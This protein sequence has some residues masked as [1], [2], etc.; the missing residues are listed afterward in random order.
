MLLSGEIS[1]SVYFNAVGGD[2]YRA[3]VEGEQDG[4]EAILFLLL[5]SLFQSSLESDG[6]VFQYYSETEFRHLQS[7]GSLDWPDF[8]KAFPVLAVLVQMSGNLFKV[9]SD[10]GRPIEKSDTWKDLIR[11]MFNPF[12]MDPLGTDNPK[13]AARASHRLGRL[14]RKTVNSPERLSKLL[15]GI[16]HTPFQDKGLILTLRT[17]GGL[18][19]RHDVRVDHEEYRGLVW[20]QR[21]GK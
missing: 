1:A 19:E 12:A 14:V 4:F 8:E 5:S 17:P 11:G 13:R 21:S 15:S 7:C 16:S 2:L 3:G 20:N 18:R 10:L 6:K 9:E